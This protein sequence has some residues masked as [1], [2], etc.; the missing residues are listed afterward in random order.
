MAIGRAESLS[1]GALSQVVV[2][3]RVWSGG[4]RVGRAPLSGGPRIHPVGFFG[5]I[6]PTYHA[7]VE[8]GHRGP[9]ASTTLSLPWSPVG[10]RV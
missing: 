8:G 9:A 10:F 6:R 3:V 5:D 1:R 4:F 2:R 7:T